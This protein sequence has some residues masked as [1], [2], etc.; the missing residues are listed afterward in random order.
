MKKL[1]LLRHA[2]SSWDDPGLDDHDRVLNRRG[3]AAVPVIGGWLSSRRHIPDLV[4]CSSAVR[5]RQTI[6]G[7]RK[8]I[9]GIPA[10]IIEADLYHASPERMLERLR[11]LPRTCSTVML[12][13]HQPG[14][15]S[16]TRQLADG[17]ETR[18]CRRAFEHFPT[19]AAAVL[20]LTA[21]DWRNLHYG[22]ARF[23]DFAKPKELM[24]A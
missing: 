24:D 12:V 3:K 23:T 6:D 9:A 17:T 20:E 2:K 19:A 22:S 7:L 16:L 10:P 11:A 1:I 13:G 14:I 21:D 8:A 4:L 18:R 15:G 5:T